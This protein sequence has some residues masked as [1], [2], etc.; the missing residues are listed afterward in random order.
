MQLPDSSSQQHLYTEESS[1]GDSLH[2]APVREVKSQ[3]DAELDYYLKRHD[4]KDEGFDVVVRYALDGDA[5]LAVYLPHGRLTL[6][7]FFHPLSIGGKLKQ[8][9]IQEKFLLKDALD[10]I[11]IGRFESD[12][13]IIGIRIDSTGVYGG[14]MTLRGEARGHGIYRAALISKGTGSTTNG[15][16]SD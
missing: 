6:N 12:S 16:A 15:K 3:F 14:T 13:L 9:P 7:S 5:A 11:I 4:P 1:T 8:H 2:P 10:R